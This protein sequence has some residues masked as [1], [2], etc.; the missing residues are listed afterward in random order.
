[1]CTGL[2]EAAFHYLTQEIYAGNIQTLTPVDI[3]QQ[4]SIGIKIQMVKH[5][6]DF[7]FGPFTLAFL[8]LVD[9]GL[10]ASFGSRVCCND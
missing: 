2:A 9:S 1:M 10:E 5:L 6:S 8:V 3:V 4:L 7:T